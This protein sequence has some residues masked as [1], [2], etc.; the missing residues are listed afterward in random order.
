VSPSQ[1]RRAP[2]GHVLH[3]PLVAAALLFGILVLGA[4][5]IAPVVE[6]AALTDAA[7]VAGSAILEARARALAS[8]RC[9]RVESRNQ[10]RSV[11]VLRAPGAGCVAAGEG[12]VVDV[13][14]LPHKAHVAAK[15]PIAFTR[16]G[17]LTAA[18]GELAVIVDDT[19]TNVRVDRLG[20]ACVRLGFPGLACAEDP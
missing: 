7:S 4:R 16:D 2:R 8:G 14:E 17:R 3:E 19:I 15:E 10:G 5:P 13:R 9:H 20:R 1:A 6:R 12:D 18:T 11:V